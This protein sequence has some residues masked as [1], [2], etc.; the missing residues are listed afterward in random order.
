MTY[1]T[2][3]TAQ[4]LNDLVS[5]QELYMGLMDFDGLNPAEQVLVGTWELVN[6][7]YNGGFTQYFQSSSGARA[8][9]MIALLRSIDANPAAG[10]LEDAAALI[11]PKTRRSDERNNVGTQK[12]VDDLERAFY[13]ELDNLHR[14]VFDYLSKHRDAID[15]PP[16]FWTEPMDQ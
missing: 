2:D 7:V 14:L 9:P 12:R 4:K 10:I 15:A 3:P 6:E 1:E 11:D 8:K 16:E 5:S 13:A